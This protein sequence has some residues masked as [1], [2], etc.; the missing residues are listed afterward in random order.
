[1]CISIKNRLHVACINFWTSLSY[2]SQITNTSENPL[3]P[4]LDCGAEETSTPE[5]SAPANALQIKRV[6]TVAT[7]PNGNATASSAAAL[8]KSGSITIKAKVYKDTSLTRPLIAAHDVTSQGNT[9]VLDKRSLAVKSQ[10]ADLAGDILNR[11]LD[12]LLAELCCC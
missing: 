4:T 7:H 11:L 10:A 3:P 6:P 1:M 2:Y 8:V 5:K 12:G 9:I